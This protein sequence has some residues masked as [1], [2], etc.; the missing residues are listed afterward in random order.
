MII[1]TTN[2]NAYDNIPNHYYDK[3]VK[4]VMFYDKPIQQ[5]GP[6]EFIQVEEPPTHLL[7]TDSIH[8]AYKT[9]TLSHLYFD[10]PHVWVDGCYTMTEQFVKNSKEFL[11]KDEITLMHHPDK[12]TLLQEILKLYRCGFVPEDRLLK[13][14]TDVAATGMK[15]SFFDHTIN[16][17]IWRHNTPK[18]REWN[19]QYWHWYE[20]YGLFHGCQITSAIAE[21]LVYGKITARAPLQVDLSTSSRAKDYEDSY[22]FTTN[23]S[24][25]EFVTKARKILNAVDMISNNPRG[26]PSATGKS[27]DD[28]LI[29]YTCI[30]NGYDQIPEQS[31][32]DPDVRYVCFH[33]GTID[34]TV[35]SWEYIELDLDIEDPRDYSYYVKAHP[36]EFFPDNS[37]TVWI[38][39]CFILT[40]E[41]ID[42]S[43]KSFPFSVLRHGGKFSY[44]DEM[45]EGYTCAFFKHEDAINL[46]SA[47]NESGY[48]FKKYSSPQCTILWRKLTEDVKEFDDVWYAWGSKN[49]NRDNI[50]FDAA[51]QITGIKP[52][53]YDGRDDSG[54]DLGF[55]NKVGRRGKHPQ[56][57]DVKQY[58]NVDKFLTDLRE[59]TNLH[60]KAYARYANH[61]FY[62]K[63]YNII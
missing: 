51:M 43:K 16:C 32:Y 7:L 57:G 10:E 40:K 15:S 38:D 11:E 34:T 55:Y 58:L 28:Q 52:S 54:I 26:C 33:D 9:R 45:L 29:V 14:C 49:Y 48:N 59:I 21:Y 53:F 36:H 39:G 13:F 63:E 18:V 5:K 46:T 27:I 30:T 35:G 4:Y 37:Y 6:W 19:E 41:F 3:D 23:N 17:C 20:H 22:I 50:P 1:F 8:K 60:P 24:E 12:R 25:E 44:Y 62:M 31:Y 61:G 47:L 2:V 56:H 42:N